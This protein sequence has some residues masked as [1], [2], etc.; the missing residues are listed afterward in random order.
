MLNLGDWQAEVRFT[1]DFVT[2][3]VAAGGVAV[4]WFGGSSDRLSRQTRAVVVAGFVALGAA[5][6]ADRTFPASGSASYLVGALRALATVLLA[7]GPAVGSWA[8]GRGWIDRWLWWGGLAV[9]AAVV[10]AG[11]AEGP[12]VGYFVGLDL[13]SAAIGTA[14]VRSGRRAVATRVATAAGVSLM[15]M[16]LLLS[17][18]LS[19]IVQTTARNQAYQRLS[20]AANG[21]ATSIVGLSKDAQSSAY[22]FVQLVESYTRIRCPT[23]G[24]T[25][26]CISEAVKAYSQRYFPKYASIWVSPAGSVLAT[27]GLAGSPALGVAPEALASTPVVSQA[28]SRHSE[29]AAVTVVGGRVLAF[30][31]VPDVRATTGS[32]VSLRGT[33][34]LAVPIGTSYLT[35][36]SHSDTGISLAVASR[37]G[38]AS[39]AGPA[40]RPL[41]GS[42]MIDAALATN[43]PDRG[44]S[45]NYY[46]WVVP[47]G[48]PPGTSG[49]AVVAIESAAQ[50]AAA[51]N[52][53][54]GTL[55]VIAMGCTV[56]ALVAAGLVG[57]GVGSK[58]RRLTTALGEVREGG[59]A[60]RS[61]LVADDEI[62]SLGTAFDAMAESIEDKT[63]ALQMAA[64]DEARLRGRLEAVVS[65]M[66]DALVA[67]DAAGV[68]TDFNPAAETLL[69]MSAS[70]VVGRSL[71]DVVALVDE[72]GTAKSASLD[73]LATEMGSRFDAFV[74]PA[75]GEPVPVTCFGASL[76]GVGSSVDGA[77]YVLRDLRGER[78]ME[79]MKTEFLSRIGHELRTP[80]TGI[81]GFADL[82]TRHQVSPDRMRDWHGQILEQ[83]K[84]IGRTVELLEFVA[85]TG[86]GRVA[87]QPS[88]LD[89]DEVV[90]D[91]VA[92]WQGRPEGERVVR[93]PPPE[94]LPPVLA[95]RRWLALALDELVDN[96]VKFSPKG[97]R[98]SV[99]ARSANEGGVALTV[100]DS[101]K[102]MT[103]EEAAAAFGEF[104][105]GDS[106]DT[107][108]FG[109]LGLGLVLVRRVAESHGGWVSCDSMVGA[110]SRMAVHL[111]AEA[112][113]PVPPTP[114]HSS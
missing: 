41:H 113:D 65:A 48:H 44:R 96:A 21:A 32:G 31:A 58:L 40:S 26:P 90:S 52:A 2:F 38:V 101:G 45:G 67:V 107:R 78:E 77:V 23:A 33:A 7:L 106:S 94:P 108:A 100:V 97:G 8:G 81:V 42:R 74:Q 55:F 82:L 4:I 30:G 104:V 15:A 68:V 91:A 88:P 47:I 43:A 3:M 1:S 37:S 36:A 89:L 57:E 54:F 20:A 16:V 69:K 34:V 72:S 49:T 39:S 51:Q 109:G 9:Q 13:A 50:V 19:A 18:A 99:G 83:A 56:L 80:L 112:P 73:E 14:L 111:P 79:R 114:A 84:R 64:E 86:A 93:E 75:T 76:E 71:T 66:E 35:G 5:A 12:A 103:A 25:S 70:D 17:V 46:L 28:A 102:G 105:Q 11:F 10:A 85:A 62:G 53:L 92:R 110:G 60:V 22:L 61:G 95:D 27:G 29:A 63:S 6:F 87:L 59:I 98:V 24:P